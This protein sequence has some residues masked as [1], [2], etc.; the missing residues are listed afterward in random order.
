MEYKMLYVQAAFVL[1]FI[2]FIFI[3]VF[4]LYDN[5]Y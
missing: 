3:L 4:S 2:I 5:V 1:K